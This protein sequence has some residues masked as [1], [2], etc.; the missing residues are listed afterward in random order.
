MHEIDGVA[1]LDQLQ[2]YST[3]T[4][5]VLEDTIKVVSISGPK[6]MTVSDILPAGTTTN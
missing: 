6:T 2:A 5:Q 4:L 3:D 1:E